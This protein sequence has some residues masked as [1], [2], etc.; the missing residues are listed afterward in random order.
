MAKFWLFLLG[1]SFC[2]AADVLSIGIRTEFR[3]ADLDHQ[4]YLPPL[5]E[6]FT[7]AA[8][9]EENK[10]TRATLRKNLL[11]GY[12]KKIELTPSEIAD[13]SSAYKPEHW[14]LEGWAVSGRV[15]EM[16]LWGGTDQGVDTCFP[17]ESLE[18]IA[19]SQFAFRFKGSDSNK[20]VFKGKTKSGKAYRIELSLSQDI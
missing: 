3:Y 17:P 16:L 10:I 9:V 8:E 20:A 7:L 12:S 5:A 15:L 13:I 11:S 18:T 2:F 6:N 1:S 19:P 4:C 14:V